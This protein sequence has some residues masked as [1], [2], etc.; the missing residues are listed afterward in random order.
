MIHIFRKLF[1]YNARKNKK[2]HH[3]EKKL[4]RQDITEITYG[5]INLRVQA[6][7]PTSN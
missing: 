4:T 5:E 3:S 6:K 7:I 2:K 1:L